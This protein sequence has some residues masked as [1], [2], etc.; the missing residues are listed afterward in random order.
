MP[1]WM[2][3][4][5]TINEKAIPVFIGLHDVASEHGLIFDY[6]FH[7]FWLTTPQALA[8]WNTGPVSVT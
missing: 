4:P 6:R 1:E 3:L 7:S 8:T 2:E 5:V